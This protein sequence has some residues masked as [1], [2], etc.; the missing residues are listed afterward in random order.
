[1][2]AAE[3]LG[4]ALGGAPA[5]ASTVSAQVVDV[6]DTGVNLDYQGALLLN[7]PCPDSYRGRAAGDWVA[8]RPGTNPVVLWRLG[9]IPFS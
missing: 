6:T 2:S 3:D 4:R 7:V 8:V 1:M 5:G 9:P